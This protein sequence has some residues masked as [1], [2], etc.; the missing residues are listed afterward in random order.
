MEEPLADLAAY[1][2]A[3]T[4]LSGEELARLTLAARAAGS[5][6][7]AIAAACG[8]T[9]YKDLAGV[10]C[11]IT[12][13]TGAELLFSATQDAVRQLAG[14]ERYY[15]PLTCHVLDAASR[16]RTAPRPGGPSTSSTATTRAAPGWPATRP[17]RMTGAASRS[18]A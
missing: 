9:T 16:S 2:R 12:G 11:R 8:V 7:D 1:F 4:R 14:S 17:P 15:L 5:R 18:P 3:G 6:W 10:T 13:E